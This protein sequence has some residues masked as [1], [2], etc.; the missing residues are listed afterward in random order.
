MINSVTADIAYNERS[1]VGGQTV[2][3]LND[4]AATEG[5]RGGPL[6]NILYDNLAWLSD[7]PLR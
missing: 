6:R 2:L 4:S 3:I 5:E 7:L 1:R